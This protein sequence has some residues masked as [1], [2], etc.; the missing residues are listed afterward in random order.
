MP[1]PKAD[2]AIW[3]ALLAVYAVF[4]LWYTGV[5]GPLSAE[6]VERYVERMAASGDANPGDRARLRAFL[7]G[8]TGGDFVMSNA[9]L[10]R[11]EPLRVGPVG[12]DESSADVMRRYMR[13]MFPAMLARASHPLFF[14]RAVAPALDVW[15]IE[16][17]YAWTMA[18][19]VRYRSRR[20]LME[21]ATD[22]RFHDSH[23]F[24]VAAIEKTVAFPVEPVLRLGDPRLLLG[25]ALF[26]LAAGLQRIARAGRR[27]Q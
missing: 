7:E 2:R 6:E 27:P 3:I 16:N 22:P 19:L 9:I 1:A 4:W 26:P 11:K 5:R 14:G 13:Y 21:I 12:P 17:A 8:D 18:G 10:M 25:L 15:G 23:D 20:D 24:K